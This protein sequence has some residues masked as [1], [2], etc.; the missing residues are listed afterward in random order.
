MSQ[1]TAIIL[2]KTDR[3][4]PT[5]EQVWELVK[6]IGFPEVDRGLF[7][8]TIDGAFSPFMAEQADLTIESLNRVS[9]RTV[10]EAFESRLPHEARHVYYWHGTSFTQEICASLKRS[11]EG[12]YSGSLE[13]V[14]PTV[15]V[16]PCSEMLHDG[17]NEEFPEGVAFIGLGGQGGIPLS[18]MNR[19][20]EAVEAD[21]KVQFFL[22]WLKKHWGGE[23]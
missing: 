1:E 4:Q 7:L 3:Q 21:I 14:L 17:K 10:R 19:Y 22:H 23:W 2:M 8:T 11:T 9:L 6:W 15:V 18:P 16:G 5:V 13:P 12:L 20:D